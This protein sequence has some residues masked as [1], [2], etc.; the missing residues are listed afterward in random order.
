MAT[1]K[2]ASISGPARVG[3]AYPHAE[4]GG[5]RRPSYGQTRA[6]ARAKRD[7]LQAE[8]NDAVPGAIGKDTTLAGFMEHWLTKTLPQ[9]VAAGNIA[10]GTLDSYRSNAELHNLPDLGKIT[11]RNL[12]APTIR[13]WQHDLSKGPALRQRL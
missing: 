3:T 5:K 9:V 7:A 10:P 12:T 2:A 6:E 13:Q 8:L 4:V 1:G 11:L